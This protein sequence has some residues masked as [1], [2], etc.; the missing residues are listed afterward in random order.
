MRSGDVGPAGVA[1]T[2][3]V[4]LVQVG[5]LAALAAE[6][7]RYARPAGRALA[8][9]DRGR[10]RRPALASRAAAGVCARRAQRPTVRAGRDG[11]RQRGAC[12]AAVPLLLV[13]GLGAWCWRG[14]GCRWWRAPVAGLA[15]VVVTAAVVV[16]CTRRLGG[17]TGDVLGAV[18]RA[19]V[20]RRRPRS[21]S[22]PPDAASRHRPREGHLDSARVGTSTNG[23]LT[24]RQ[25]RP[26]PRTSTTTSSPSADRAVEQ[27]ERDALLQGRREGAG[28]RRRRPARRPSGHRTPRP[29]RSTR[30][31]R[32]GCPGPARAARAATGTPW[33][34]ARRPAPSRPQNAGFFQPTAQ[35][36]RA[37]TGVMSSDS[38]CPCSGYPISVRS[39]S[40]APS[41]AGRPPSGG[42]ASSSASHSAPVASQRRHQLVAALAGVPGAADHD[43]AALPGRVDEAHVLVTGRQPERVEHLVAARALHGDARRTT[44]ARRSRC[45]P[46]GAAPGQPAHHL[47]GVRGVR[48]EQH[49]VVGAQV[50]DEVVDDAAG[51]RRSTSCTAPGPA[52]S[53]PGRWSGAELTYAAAP[54]PR[55][56]ALP[57]WLTSNTPTALAHGRVLAHDAAARVLDRHLPAAEVGH[58][59][60]QRDVPVV[61]RRR[62]ERGVGLESAARRRAVSAMAATYRDAGTAP[63]PP[64]RRRR[65]T[66]RRSDAA[67]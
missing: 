38:S 15:A 17:I 52:R 33:P 53:G 42:A 34:P 44:R 19:V 13:V 49:L 1:T 26:R 24:T 56:S 60:A 6:R 14:P 11:R 23:G 46:S 36:A 16:R 41:P 65:R 66:S 64:S 67:T 22:R 12:P 55:T 62:V 50:D 59:R 5:C 57:R 18:R 61:Q 37:C 63:E 4:L 20:H 30:H 2:V 29:R 48:H 25:R 32:A 39:V 27:R 9:R 21:C 35:P 54:G 43:R 28:R 8:T 40:R 31:S 58:L 3:L 47:R 51:R 45:T 10:P 7:G